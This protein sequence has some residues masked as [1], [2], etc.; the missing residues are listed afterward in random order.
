MLNGRQGCHVESFPN[1]RP[2]A[3]S[4]ALSVAFTTAS[5]K[6]SH[7]Y[8]EPRLSE[9]T[10]K[11]SR[12]RELGDFLTVRLAELIKAQVLCKRRSVR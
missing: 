10:S 4:A 8:A 5:I 3:P 1:R 12:A 6:R 9:A 11:R 2:A 7:A